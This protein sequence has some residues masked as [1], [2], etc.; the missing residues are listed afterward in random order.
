MSHRRQPRCHL[1]SPMA[2]GDVIAVLCNGSTIAAYVNGILSARLRAG[3]L[4][5]RARVSASRALTLD[6]GFAI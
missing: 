4:T 1:L 6:P 2:S 5:T 3:P